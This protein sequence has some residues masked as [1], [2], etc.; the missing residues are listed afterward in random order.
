MPPQNKK[1]L[2][3]KER[4]DRQKRIIIIA[5]ISILVVVFGLVAYGVFDRFVLTPKTTIIELEGKNINATEFDQQIRWRRRNMIVD[6]DQMLMTFQQLGGTPEVF[7]YIEQQ[8]MLSVT[9]LQQPLM[10]GQEVLNALLQDIILQVEAENM[11][12]VVDDARIDQ[13][14]QEAFGFYANGTPTPAVTQAPTATPETDNGPAITATPLLQPTE[15]TEDLF[16]NNF[17]EFLDSIKLEGISEKTIR[18]II[19]T[20]IIRQEIID[21]VSAD[22]EQKAEHV[23]IRHILVEEEDTAKEVLAKLADGEDFADLAAEY[24]LDTSNKENGGDLDWFPR[25]QMVPAFE[26]I[27]FSLEVGDISEPVQTDFGWHILECLGKDDL[28]LDPTSYEQLRNQ[29]YSDWFTEKESQYQPIINEDWNKYVPT[30]PALPQEYLSYI[31]SLT[32]E[33]PQLPPDIPASE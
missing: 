29:A 3:Q 24:S 12:I 27:A 4:E 23:W 15:Y 26:E 7:A 28:L 20:S 14:I 21:I 30:E 33:Q 6:I 5:T 8:L 17:Q 25:G 1:F 22:V 13:E 18:Q 16:N 31:Q 10:I 32:L 2:A 19:R 9:S 11:G